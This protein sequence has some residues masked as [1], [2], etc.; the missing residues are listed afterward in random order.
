[1]PLRPVS[2]YTLLGQ[3][4][5]W[6]G[7]RREELALYLAVS[8]E[9]VRS[10]EAGRRS[11]TPPVADAMLP[12]ARLLPTDV[13][14]L[15]APLPSTLPPGYAAPDADELDFRR[16]VC[17]HRAGR[18]RA[19][20]DKLLRRAHYAQRWATALPALLPPPAH[21]RAAW[22]TDWLHRRARPL[23]PADVTRWHLLQAQAQA[24]E[25][26]AATLAAL[27]P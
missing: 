3:I 8:P 27:L 6:F 23:S 11:L 21:E 12:L 18:L 1:M 2:S 10:I 13:A 5:A 19:A 7:L 20:A 24:L 16:R 17:L 9:L 25:T 14:L 4:R 26:E 22:L 15:D